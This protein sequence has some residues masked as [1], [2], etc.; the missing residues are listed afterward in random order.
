MPGDDIFTLMDYILVL[1]NR[2]SLLFWALAI[3]YFIYGLAKFIRNSADTDG[4]EEGKTAMIW[5]LVSLFVLTSIWGI[6]SFILFDSLKV[7]NITELQFRDK[8]GVLVP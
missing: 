1:I 8:N 2:L 5:G 7:A 6:T 3:A 4:H